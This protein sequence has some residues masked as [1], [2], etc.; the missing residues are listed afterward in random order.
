V[1]AEEDPWP[2][3]RGQFHAEI[4]RRH[5]TRG[6]IAAE[7]GVSKGSVCGW[8]VPT[9]APPSAANKTKIRAW[10]DEKAPQPAPAADWPAL[11]EQLRGIVRERALT[12]AELGRVFE[13]EGA[14]VGMWLA[15]SHEKRMPGA[16]FLLRIEQWLH[17]GAVMPASA[18]ADAPPFVLSVEE[19]AQIAG[20]LSL[21]GNGRELRETFG[22]TREL[23]EQAASGAH[24]DAEVI[25]RL[26]GVLAPGCYQYATGAKITIDPIL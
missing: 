25:S 7:L 19:R 17:E 10:V 2:A 11:R 18:A 14:T 4:R 9:G 12:H 22:C 20:H 23:L 3:L 24:L 6:Q 1:T 26:R 5:L 15:P 21:A 16:R 13:V 8:L